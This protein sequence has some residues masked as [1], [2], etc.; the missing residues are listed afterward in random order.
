MHAL[1]RAAGRGDPSEGDCHAGVAIDAIFA[2]VEGIDDEHARAVARVARDQRDA[3]VAPGVRAAKLHR[4]DAARSVGRSKKSFSR[5]FTSD[6]QAI[7]QTGL[8]RYRPLERSAR[9]HFCS[10]EKWKT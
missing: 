5:T 9:G 4:A 3:D 8:E 7:G 10:A 1:P 6:P 2:E